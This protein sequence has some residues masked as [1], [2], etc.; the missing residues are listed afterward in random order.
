MF[1]LW[2]CDVGC[3]Q[4]GCLKWLSTNSPSVYIYMQKPTLCHQVSLLYTGSMHQVYAQTHI[5]QINAYN[6]I[7]MQKITVCHCVFS[8]YTGYTHNKPICC[9]PGAL[10]WCL[11]RCD[12]L[13][14]RGVTWVGPCVPLC[15]HLV[16]PLWSPGGR[17]WRGQGG[18]LCVVLWLGAPC[19]LL[20]LVCLC[21]C[22]WVWFLWFLWFLLFVLFVLFLCILSVCYLE[23]SNLQVGSL[24]SEFL[25]IGVLFCVVVNCLCLLFGSFQSVSWKF[26]FWISVDWCFV[27]CCCELFVFVVWKFPV[28]KLEVWLLN[29]FGVHLR[30]KFPIS[31]FSTMG[32]MF[33]LKV[34]ISRL[35]LGSLTSNF[36][37]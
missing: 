12:P 21:Y 27:L 24:T 36:D 35:S 32:W 15:P 26:D 30:W 7:S 17:P 8:V 4:S 2:F 11:P 6:N 10:L 20:G 14:R 34:D 33:D 31:S 18:H 13:R 25:W 16:S 5:K 22:G 28:C 23:V 19:G 29:L 1:F 9:L 3:L 37:R